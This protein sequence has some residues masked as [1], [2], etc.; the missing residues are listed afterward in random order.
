VNVLTNMMNWDPVAWMSILMV[1]IAIVI[2][3]F[4]AFKVKALMNQD[5][6]AHKHQ[7]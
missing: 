1:V 6:E 2:V 4:L 7:D 5:A 3:V